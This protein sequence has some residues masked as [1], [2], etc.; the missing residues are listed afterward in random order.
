[1]NRREAREARNAHIKLGLASKA[2][3][4]RLRYAAFKK[5]HANIDAIKNPKSLNS[6]SRTLI[7]DIL[8]LA[9]QILRTQRR[10]GQP[11]K[12]NGQRGHSR[13]PS[14]AKTPAGKMHQHRKLIWERLPQLCYSGGEIKRYVKIRISKRTLGSESH[15]AMW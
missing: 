13:N 15:Q 6:I 4:F 7:Y 9:N 1:M 3:H 10:K 2:Y 8:L 12:E 11:T 14:K 5:K